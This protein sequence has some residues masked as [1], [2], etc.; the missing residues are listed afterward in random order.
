MEQ[1]LTPPLMLSLAALCL[2]ALNSYYARKKD[3]KQALDALEDRLGEAEANLKVL[4]KQMELFWRT[5]EQQMA[6]KFKD[7]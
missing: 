7:E 6:K 2:G 1:W 3:N 4:S 5:V